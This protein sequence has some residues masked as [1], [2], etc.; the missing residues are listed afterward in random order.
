MIV[1]RHSFG[2]A[3]FVLAGMLVC[4]LSSPS[5]AAAAKAGTRSAVLSAAPGTLVRWSVPGTLRC[6]L[7]GEDAVDAEGLAFG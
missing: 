5:S 7:A 1:D 4:A 3:A 2:A 6:R